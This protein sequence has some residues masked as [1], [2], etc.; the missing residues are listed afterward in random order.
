MCCLRGFLSFVKVR[1]RWCELVVK[2]K[3]TTAYKTV[4]RFLQED[5]VGRPHSSGSA[6]AAAGCPGPKDNRYLNIFPKSEGLVGADSPLRAQCPL[7]HRALVLR[8]TIGFTW[9]G[10]AATERGLCRLHGITGLGSRVAQSC[11]CL[12]LSSL[13]L[14]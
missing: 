11:W 2:H 1:H 5:Q 10:V 7:T 6:G 8:G 13:V 9:G 4:E 12:S 14:T 3:Y